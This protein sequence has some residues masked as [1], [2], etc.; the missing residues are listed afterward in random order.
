M[1][2]KIKN[3]TIELN[4]ELHEFSLEDLEKEVSARKQLENQLLVQDFQSVATKIATIL[5][6][7]L[8]VKYK[9]VEKTYNSTLSPLMTGNIK[10]NIMNIPGAVLSA[11][12]SA[13]KYGVAVTFYFERTTAPP[14][15]NNGAH[16][17]LL[18]TYDTQ[19]M[20]N[21]FL[22]GRND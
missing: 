19:G 16:Q 4:Q 18:P 8:K 10:S 2:T 20:Q 5:N 6:D 12:T 15:N 9:P 22:L 17:V 7:S 1:T 3:N 13:N 21:G 14:A 11:S